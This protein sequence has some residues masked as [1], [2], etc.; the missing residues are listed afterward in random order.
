MAN[1][2]ERVGWIGTGR[3]GYAMVELLLAARVPVSVWN[4]TRSKAE[5]LQASGAVIATLVA[6][7]CHPEVLDPESPDVTADYPGHLCREV[8]TRDGGIAVFVSGDLGGMQSPATEHRTHEEAHRFGRVLADAV[9]DCLQDSQDDTLA[10]ARMSLP[11]DLDNPMYRHLIAAGVVA[12]VEWRGD[13]VLTEVSLTRIGPVTLAAVPGELLPR[14]G[15]MVRQQLRAAGSPLPA[16]VG[17][18]DDELGYIL[19]AEDFVEPADYLDPGRQYEESMSPG[20][21][22]GP[23]V[24]GALTE[25][26][27]AV[28]P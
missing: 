23:A 25:L 4:R 19:A 20:R 28:L 3:M 15:L 11:I 21:G 12:P 7:P 14:L 10:F 5:P 18:A 24:M 6:Y 13:E 22:T 17:L 1:T 16:I 26:I 9:G 27:P 8:E 2:N